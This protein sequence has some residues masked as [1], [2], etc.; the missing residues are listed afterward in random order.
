MPVLQLPMLLNGQKPMVSKP[1][2]NTRAYRGETSIY[3]KK[4]WKVWSI[5][6]MHPVCLLI[7]VAR[8][9]VCTRCV[10]GRSVSMPVSL[11]QKNQMHSTAVTWLPVRKVCLLHS[12]F[13][14]TADT[15]PITNVLWVT[16]VKPVYLSVRWK[17]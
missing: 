6:T 14:L 3:K 8:I 11:P 9:A 1:I 10:P 2:E 5:C 12:T 15:M 13:R 4:I 17:T 7:C 16:L